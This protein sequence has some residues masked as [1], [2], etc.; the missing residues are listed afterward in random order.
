MGNPKYQWRV[1]KYNPALRDENGYFTLKDEWIS[2]SAIGET[3]NGVEFTL[4]EYLRVESAY[5]ESVAKFLADSNLTFLR[6]LK[7]SPGEI[8]AEEKAS[9]LYERTFDSLSLS[10]DALVGLDEIKLIC[11]MVLRNFIYCQFY[12]DNHFFVHFGWD[13]YMYIGSDHP[14]LTAIRFAEKNGLFVE[15]FTS[16]YFIAPENVVREIEWGKINE[17]TLEDSEALPEIPLTDY[18][19]LFM[20]SAS[21][22]II[23]SFPVTEDHQ[24]FFQPLLNHQMDFAKYTY[25]LFC[26]D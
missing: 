15:N 21:H 2:A 23:G 8:T 18:R 3:F 16:P 13:Y 1:T 24:S 10:E 7:F 19:T 4:E 17:E 22:P 26:S 20:L 9:D 5:I 12:F 25:Q 14:S 11:K 6:I